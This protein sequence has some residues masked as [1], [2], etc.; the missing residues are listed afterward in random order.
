VAALGVAAVDRRAVGARQRARRRA[1]STDQGVVEGE[2]ARLARLP[3]PTRL[4]RAWCWPTTSSSTRPRWRPID[5]AAGAQ[6]RS[7]SAAAPIGL[8]L[9]GR[10]T[11][12]PVR[13][14]AARR[15]SGRGGG[16]RFP[17]WLGSGLS[18]ANA[19]SAVARDAMGRSSARRASS[20]GRVDQPVDAG[21]GAR[22][23]RR[24]SGRE[25]R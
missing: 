12:E 5:A 21:A 2:A 9:S 15:P 6:R 24:L 10:R 16:R 17:I 22:A 3:S 23:A 19:A 13:P 8:V 7:P 4:R 1:T 14:R 20:D 18:L 11:G 25:P